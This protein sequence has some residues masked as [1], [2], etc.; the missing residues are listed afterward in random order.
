LSS[1]CILT[2]D[3]DWAPDF[4]IED[5]A[6]L[7][8]QHRVRSTWFVTHA[9]P[10]ID[11]LSD[12]P[13]LFELGIHPNFLPGSSHGE[14]HDEVLHYCQS[15]IPD[16]ISCRT[17]ALAQSA[18]ILDALI[19]HNVAI[20]VSLFLP[21]A[22]HLVPT[23]YHSASG[24]LFR[25]PFFWEDC[26][27]S[28]RETPRWQLEDHNVESPGLK[29]FSFHPIH[30]FL[31]SKSMASYRQIKSASSPLTEVGEGCLKPLVNQGVGARSLFLELVNWMCATQKHGHIRDLHGRYQQTPK[32]GY[33]SRNRSLNVTV[34][35]AD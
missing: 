19:R 32:D 18:P 26:C 28:H 27:E 25:A 14:A 11:A 3:V 22:T 34:N 30:L 5:V 4:V 35:P 23:F 20:D 12:E 7:L 31:N 33:S 1:D 2:L 13:D 9:S 29:I 8:R 6:N 10:A 16:A 21:D 17:H 24:S 15:I